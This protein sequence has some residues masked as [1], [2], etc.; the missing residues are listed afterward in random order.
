MYCPSTDP[1]DRCPQPFWIWST[2]ANA[3]N[4]AKRSAAMSPAAPTTDPTHTFQV[5]FALPGADSLE[6]HL[7]VLQ[8]AGCDDAA[9]I[10]PAGD[11][12]F[13]AEFDR[14]ASSFAAAVVSALEALR[15]ALTD[16]V[17]LR[18]QPEDIV[19][20]SAIAARTG[21]TD[22]SVRLLAQGRRGPGSFPPAA[23]WI[24]DK[25]Q[26]WRWADVA[27][28]FGDAL[29]E[30]PVGSEHAAFL[31][32]L[33]D[34]LDLAARAADLRERPDELEAVLRFLPKQQAAA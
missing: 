9:F 15:S 6:P 29:G 24:N 23:G 12:T 26:V 7:D 31:A 4:H 22:E 20:L 8:A 28:W 32:A 13:I 19:S 17:L 2:P 5:V 10:G 18:M 11:G 25:T 21:R 1:N 16:A 30:P 34:A 3:A 14:E 33:N 27:R